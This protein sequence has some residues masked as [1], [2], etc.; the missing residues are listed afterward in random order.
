MMNVPEV[1]HQME[2]HIDLLQQVEKNA[3]EWEKDIEAYYEK[4]GPM[5]GENSPEPVISRIAEIQKD[6]VPNG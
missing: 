2:A 6:T 3:S 5:P 1:K 4:R